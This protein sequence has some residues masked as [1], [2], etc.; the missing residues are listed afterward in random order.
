MDKVITHSAQLQCFL[1]NLGRP[2]VYCKTWLL[3]L[4]EMEEHISSKPS[5]SQFKKLLEAGEMAQKFRALAAPAGDQSFTPN[6][7]MSAHNHP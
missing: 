7:L 3:I 6:T 1:A 4:T 2:T 5:F